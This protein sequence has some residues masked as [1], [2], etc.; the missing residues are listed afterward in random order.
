MVLLRLRDMEGTATLTGEKLEKTA[1]NELKLFS[2]H[3][4]V[5]LY[6]I[7]RKVKNNTNAPFSL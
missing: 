3:H 2:F 6:H 7:E 1:K 5:W 4:L